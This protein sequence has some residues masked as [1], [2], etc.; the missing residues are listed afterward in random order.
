MKII[1]FTCSKAVHIYE[2]GC[3]VLPMR[4]FMSH[5]SEDDAIKYL[6]KRGIKRPKFEIEGRAKVVSSS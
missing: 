6:Q 2:D 5:S 1:T 3:G 4:P